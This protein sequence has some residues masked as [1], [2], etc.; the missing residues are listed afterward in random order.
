MFYNDPAV[1]M[2]QNKKELKWCGRE[3]AYTDS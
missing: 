3:D 1:F 2:G